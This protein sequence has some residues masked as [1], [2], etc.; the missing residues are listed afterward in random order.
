MKR[1]PNDSLPKTIFCDID[2]TLIEHF[3][4]VTTSNLSHVS[5]TLPGTL[6]KL[7]EWDRKG[8]RIILT[9]GRRE[10]ARDSTEKQLNQIGIIY[11][12]LIMGLG[13]GERIIINDKKP[14]G[15]ETCRA[16]SPDRNFGISK[17]DI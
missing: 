15:R 5:Q 11:D 1:T 7:R 10:S 9:T 13:G 17:I 8:Y 6:D 4:P 2:G 16:F 14:D 3:D 12:L